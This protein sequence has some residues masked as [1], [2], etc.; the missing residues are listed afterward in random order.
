MRTIEFLSDPFARSILLSALATGLA[1]VALC[2]VCSVLVVLKRL[3]FVGQGVSHSAFG[4]IGVSAVLAATLVGV[5]MPAG[6]LVQGGVV[7]FA[8][9]LVFSIGAA[10]LMASV[11]DRRT[12]HMDTGIGILLVASMALGGVL[13]E[14]ARSIAQSSGRLAASRSWES[15]LFGSITSST[16]TDALVAWG[17]A[18]GVVALLLVIRR[19][20]VFWAFDEHAAPAFGVPARRVRVLLMVI[21]AVIVVTSMKLAGV[22]PAT[23]LLVLPGAIALRLSTRWGRVLILAILTGA[24]GVVAGLV[25]SIELDIQPGPCIVLVLSAMFALASAWTWARRRDHAARLPEGEA[26]PSTLAS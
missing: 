3:A 25:T 16:W 23:A 8:V 11:A 15:V 13:V 17:V 9:V 26:A 1:L 21:L 4:G 18:G 12:L 19:P 6:W 2:A 7:D 22:V 5:G 20:L 14:V 10:L 24:L